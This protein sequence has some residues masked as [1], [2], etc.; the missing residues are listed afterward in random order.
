MGKFIVNSFG[1]I[2]LFFVAINLMT[3]P[4]SNSINSAIASFDS[5]IGSNHVIEDG[6][7]NVRDDIPAKDNPVAVI[8]EKISSEIVNII[9]NGLDWGL[10]KIISLIE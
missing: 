10:R 9:S 7:I 6:N 1:L 5:A 8:G 4:S 3:P 2:L